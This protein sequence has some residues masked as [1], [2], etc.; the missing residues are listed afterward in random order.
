M[1]N[2]DDEIVRINIRVPRRIREHFKALG[3]KYSVPYTNYI[4]MILTQIYERQQIELALKDFNNIINSFES[5]SDLN[6]DEML[7]ELSDLENIIK[8]MNK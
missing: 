5:K 1:N 7:K 8:S 2:S 4:A 3:I 6:T